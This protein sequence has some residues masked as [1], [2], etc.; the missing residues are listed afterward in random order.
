VSVVL[1][2]WVLVCSLSKEGGRLLSLS[3]L[4]FIDY[5]CL[6]VYVGFAWSLALFLLLFIMFA[7]CQ[8]CLA[9]VPSSYSQ[10]SPTIGEETLT[11]WFAIDLLKPFYPIHPRVRC[12]TVRCLCLCFCKVANAQ[13]TSLS[14]SIHPSRM[15]MHLKRTLGPFSL[16][17]SL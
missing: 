1:F 2:V 5:S 11:G 12:K 15:T 16:S 7:H 8:A 3:L 13:V 4:P 10:C 14:T 6:I 9:C 17:L